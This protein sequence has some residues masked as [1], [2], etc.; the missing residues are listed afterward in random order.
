[1]KRFQLFVLF[2]F[3]IVMVKA[4]TD[5]EEMISSKSDVEINVVVDS[6]SPWVVIGLDSIYNPNDNAQLTIEYES[7]NMVELYIGPTSGNNAYSLTIDGGEDRSLDSYS[8]GSYTYIEPGKHAVTI[9]SKCKGQ[10]IHGISMKE[11][12]FTSDDAN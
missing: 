12:T 1:M 10:V 7:E 11:K 6:V 5:V 4:N 9:T 3:A 2:L 8:N